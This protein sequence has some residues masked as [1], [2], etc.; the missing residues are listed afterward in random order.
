MR[1]YLYPTE[2]RKMWFWFSK[3]FWLQKHRSMFQVVRTISPTA[4]CMW[5]LKTS[6]F[7]VNEESL[8]YPTFS[9][10]SLLIFKGS[11]LTAKRA[12]ERRQ[13]LFPLRLTWQGNDEIKW[14]LRLV[15]LEEQGA[16]GK[17]TWMQKCHSCV[18]ILGSLPHAWSIL[19]FPSSFFGK[20][21]W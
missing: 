11:E 4:V 10:L 19:H 18:R 14:N 6:F 8:C 5:W 12:H 17:R 16:V 15:G 3:L 7:K 2:L 21:S 9:V 13:Q 1:R 20:T